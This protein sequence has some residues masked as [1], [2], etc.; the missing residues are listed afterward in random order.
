M[1]YRS[2]L[3]NALPTKHIYCL[4]LTWYIQ[5]I[6]DTQPTDTCSITKIKHT[7]FLIEW[8]FWCLDNCC[9]SYEYLDFWIINFPLYSYKTK[10]QTNM[11]I[12]YCT[13][14]I[15][16]AFL[17]TTPSEHVKLAHHIVRINLI[18]ISRR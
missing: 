13:I 10:I 12:L 2:I 1:L 9:F 11:H 16:F 3:L 14:I 18:G 7:L 15:P 4:T 6:D 17:V 5:W 8:S